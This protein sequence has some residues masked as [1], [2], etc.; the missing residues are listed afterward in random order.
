MAKL[1]IYHKIIPEI[2]KYLEGKAPD[3]FIVP[4]AMLR[5]I[6][7]RGEKV[8]SG[9]FRKYLPEELAEDYERS[10]EIARAKL[11]EVEAMPELAKA[12]RRREAKTNQDAV[13]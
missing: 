1:D 10:L 3:H 11:P 6:R 13:V 8:T 2:V 9:E 7:E 5:V 4:W 12:V